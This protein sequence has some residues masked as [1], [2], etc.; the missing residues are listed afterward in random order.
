MDRNTANFYLSKDLEMPFKLKVVSLQGLKPII[1][2]SEKILNPEIFQTLSNIY[3]NSDLFIKFLD[4]VK[5][6]A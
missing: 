3:S 2:K 6:N 4:K 1:K 5:K